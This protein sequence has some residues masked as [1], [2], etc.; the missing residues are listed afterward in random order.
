MIIQQWWDNIY[1]YF[2]AQFLIKYILFTSNF[3]DDSFVVVFVL[4]FII[5]NLFCFDCFI[6]L[7]VC[8][9]VPFINNN[10]LFLFLFCPLIRSGATFTLFLFSFTKNSFVLSCCFYIYIV[11]ICTFT[12]NSCCFLYFIIIVSFCLK[13]IVDIFVC[14]HFMLF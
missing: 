3:T 7:F 5:R 6:Y 12:D 9:Q 11:F 1:I 14:F 4:Y 2:Y 10:S 13:A 8:I